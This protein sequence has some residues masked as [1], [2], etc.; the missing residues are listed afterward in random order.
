[1]IYDLK[2]GDVITSQ[3]HYF[4]VYNFDLNIFCERIYP[5]GDKGYQ[6][7]YNDFKSGYARKCT[8]KEVNQLYKL[9]VFK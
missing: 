4:E 2:I 6:F 7:C 3:N 8:D 1:M 5:K 9:I